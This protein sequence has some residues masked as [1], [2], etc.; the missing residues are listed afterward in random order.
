MAARGT[1]GVAS[2]IAVTLVL[3]G[4]AGGVTPPA[5]P[6]NQLP[7]TSTSAPTAVLPTPSAPGPV[8]PTQSPVLVVEPPAGG[9]TMWPAPDATPAPTGYQPLVGRWTQEDD[10][11]TRVI[12][13]LP[14]GRYG[15]TL[16]IGDSPVSE[17]GVYSAD[18]STVVFMPIDEAQ[19]TWSMSLDGNVLVIVDTGGGTTIE[20]TLEP[21]SPQAVV[22]EAQV[23]DAREAELDA[24]WRA[25]L[26]V[27]RM[28]QQP[29][30]IPVGEVPDD[31]NVSKVFADATAFVSPDLYVDISLAEITLDDGTT[32]SVQNSTKWY[33]QPTGRLYSIFTNWPTGRIYD[34]YNPQPDIATYWSAYS[35]VE[36]VPTDR[37]LV[38][39]DAGEQID[40]QLTHGR[41]N[42]VWGNDVYGQV[43]WENEQLQ[44]GG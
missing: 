6:S 41:R 42:L 34:R 1:G 27:A 37:V 23:V 39:S 44:D 16:T 10:F 32:Q 19:S 12:S 26:P 7:T 17:S 9:P 38:L 11:S 22:Q 20:Y 36:G 29:A 30:H 4:C 18:G 25:R 24:Q 21:G 40:M 5:G 33:F 28:T 31:P 13:F 35:V 8:N 2:S 14:D 3:L 15:E 43:D